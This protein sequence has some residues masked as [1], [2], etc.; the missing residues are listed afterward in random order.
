M[1]TGAAAQ[2]PAAFGPFGF[3]Q[4]TSTGTQAQHFATRC[5]LKALLGRFFG[6]NTFGTSHKS[7]SFR[8]KRARNIGALTRGS[9][10]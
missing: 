7:I 4:M 8:S 2:T 10:S 1:N 5:Y 3:S 9:K 6:L